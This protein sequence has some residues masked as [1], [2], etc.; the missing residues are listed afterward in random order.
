MPRLVSPSTSIPNSSR[1]IASTQAAPCV[2]DSVHP[3]IRHEMHAVPCYLFLG[4][5]VFLTM[6]SILKMVHGHTWEYIDTAL[7][8]NDANVDSQQP[9]PF[10]SA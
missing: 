4:S 7:Q 3:R 8:S 1:P 6:Y 10:I 9:P 2:P 5:R